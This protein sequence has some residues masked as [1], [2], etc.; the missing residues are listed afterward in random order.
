M[1]S[2]FERLLRQLDPDRDRAGEEYVRIRQRLARLFVWR[3]CANADELADRVL[4][5]VVKRLDEGAEIYAADP[6]AFCHGVALMVLRETWREQAR[7]HAVEADLTARAVA[8]DDADRGDHHRERRHQCLE[9]CL[10]R[11]P[12]ESRELLRMYHAP[13]GSAIAARRQLARALSVPLN[14]LRIRVHRLRVELR[15]CIEECAGRAGVVE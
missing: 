3:G 11:M 14:A 5:R 4:E 9:R 12:A 10:A 8:S 1:T 15:A 6:Y 7:Q 13:E 2:G